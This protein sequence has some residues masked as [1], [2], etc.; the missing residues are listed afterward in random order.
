[1]PEK[2]GQATPSLPSQASVIVI[3]GGVIGCS[4]LY[5]LAKLG[6]KDA[7]LLERN[8][9]TSGTTWHSAAQV[10]QLRSTKNLTR[11]IQYSASLYAG[12]E[13]ETGQSTGWIKTGSLSIAS[14]RD[15]LT[16]IRRQLSLAKA[17]GVEAAEISVTEAARHWPLLNTEDVIGAVF[18][19][20]DGR[21]NPSDLCLALTK[22]AKARGARVF[23]DTAVTGFRLEQGRVTGVE[24]GAGTGAGTIAC[25]AAVICSGLWSRDVAALAG[26]AAPLLP[27]EHF[28]LLTKPIAGIDGHLP[29]LSDH[30][31]HLYI[32]DD[33][34]GLLVGCFEPGGKPLDPKALGEDFAFTLL[35]EDWDHFEPMMVNA[36]HRIPALETA[37]VRMLLNGPE[38]F[39]PDGSLMLGESAEVRR[40]YLCCGL[41]SVGVAT[42]GGAGL[43]MAEWVLGDQASMDL[44]E[45]DP[46]RFSPLEDSVQGL[47]ARA[48]EVLGKHYEIS[49][50]GRE[51]FSARGLKKLPLHAQYQ[52]AGATFGQRFAWERPLYFGAKE[53]SPALTFDRPAWFEQVGAEVMAA[54]RAAALFDQS[55]FGKIR[56][57]GPEAEAF[58][59]RLCANHMGRAPGRA[60]YTAM[61]NPRGG[62][63]GDLTALRLAEDDY[64]LYVG[65]TAIR[66]DLGWLARHSR[67]D[68]KIEIRDETDAY[69][70]LG[71]MGPQAGAIMQALIGE[72]LG[73]L[74][75]FQHR[76]IRIAGTAITAA[77]IS[78]VGEPGWELTLPSERAVPVH[79]VLMAA[80]AEFGLRYAG[81]NALTAMRIEKRFLAMGHDIGPDDN[82]FAAGIGFAV[83]MK[84]D[85][86]FIGR[87]ALQEI[88]AKGV[89]RQMVSIVLEDERANPLGHEPLYHRGRIVGQVTSA[90]FGYRIGRPVALGYL[91][92]AP[93][94]GNLEGQALEVDIAGQAYAGKVSTQAAFDP[95]GKRLRGET[96]RR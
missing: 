14:N 1:M 72:D 62:F 84:S 3:G 17:Y 69:A 53:T 16:H 52:A 67:P 21:V 26:V 23:E 2:F 85:I 65:T 76:A 40:L 46:R 86:D 87:S 68:E 93:F 48:P 89:K 32:R 39:T 58:L 19:P 44:G 10:R 4:T 31:S 47:T 34:G 29:T 18:S 92:L 56:V 94:D 70:V 77:R 5:H 35:P 71:L 51:W 30:D 91:D 79:D 6:V 9:L 24:T 42:G 81:A 11:L 73:G 78:Y 15:R 28:Y 74:G 43:A 66:R 50:P 88:R 83:K 27:C 82:P 8:R 33:V 75:Y 22:G 36:L 37:E 55:S 25:D 7:I 60:I 96:A 12:L 20:D 95:Y 63:E 61:L 57:T 90:A 49:Y 64:R 13:A 80:G 41:N 54:H 38:S 59:Q 45:A